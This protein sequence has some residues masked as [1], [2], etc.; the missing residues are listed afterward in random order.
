MSICLMS[1]I[2]LTIADETSCT[3]SRIP[4]T[5]S[6]ITVKISDKS[7]LVSAMHLL[8]QF[9]MTSCLMSTISLTISD[10][11]SCTGLGHMHSSELP[12]PGDVVITSVDY[13]IQVQSVTIPRDVA[14]KGREMVC[15]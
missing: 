3:G 15:I 6:G 14:V 7:F 8:W 10:E 12:D 5:F 13:E 11:T 9:C 2:S 4:L 1:T